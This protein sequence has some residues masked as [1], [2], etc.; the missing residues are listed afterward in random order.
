[1]TVCLAVTCHDPSGAFEPGVRAAGDALR[2]TFA[3]VAVNA[4]SETSPATMTALEAEIEP[5][6]SR[7]H[8]AGSVGIGAARR[9]A[10][11]MALETDCVYI[12]YSDLDHVL[13]WATLDASELERS[14]AP[15]SGADLVVIGRS[16]RVFASEPDRLR[17][18][19]G[20]VNQAASLAL[21]LRSEVWDFMIAIR[22]MTRAT[23]SLLVEHCGEESIANDV[24]WPLHAHREG[25][26]LAH[27][28]VD[29]LAYRY[30]EDYGA[31]AD[32]R[33]NDPMEWVRRIE[34]ASL[35]ATA[36]RPYLAS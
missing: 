1:M 18:T 33:D 15:P 3:A 28:A 24:A 32:D 14:M 11:A 31:P 19:E 23:A 26:A 13:R 10:L 8:Q 22:L 29:G 6:T 12:A 5:L 20:A 2:R 16:P 4:T 9:A 21:G 35:H 25:R 34:I 30:R 36:M 7:R 27:V 17:A